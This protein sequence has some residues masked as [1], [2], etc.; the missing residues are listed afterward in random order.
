MCLHISSSYP[1]K[2]NT[3]HGNLYITFS[4]VDTL[5]ETLVEGGVGF[6]CPIGDREYGLRDFSIK[7]PDGNQI[8]IGAPRPE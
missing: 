1:H 2:D 4:E 5:Y 3:G 7:D 8:G 6:Y